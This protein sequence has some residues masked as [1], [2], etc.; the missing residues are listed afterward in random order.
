MPPSGPFKPPPKP[1]VVAPK[2]SFNDSLWPLAVVN[3][4]DWV[5]L[6]GATG[7]G[8]PLPD[9]PSI[10]ENGGFGTPLC[11]APPPPPFV[12]KWKVPVSIYEPPPCPPNLPDAGV[13]A[14]P[15]PPILIVYWTPFCKANPVPT[16]TPPAPPPVA[17]SL[18]PPPPAATIK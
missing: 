5:L 1:C 11:G 17:R 13:P 14:D 2:D 18:P 9:P 10:V 3:V 4:K 6:R 7:R 12:P 8:V 16:L 15:P